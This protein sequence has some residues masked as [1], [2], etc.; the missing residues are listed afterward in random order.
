M[1]TVKAVSGVRRNRGERRVVT[2]RVVIW[3]TAAF[4]L[5]SPLIAMQFTD[6]VEWDGADF[7]LFAAM[8]VTAGGAVEFTVRM[9]GNA[10]YRAAVGI[11]IAATF[12]LVWI[13]LA[14]GVIGSEDDPANLMYGGVLAIAMMGATVAR[15]RPAGMARALG[16]TALAQTAVGAIALIAGWGSAAPSFPEAVIVLTGLFAGLWLLSGWFF[17]KAAQTPSSSHAAT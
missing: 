8:L 7:I 16:A 14:V 9:T 10:A 15:F 2:W 11:A 1:Y 6:Q 17:H 3:A 4:L 13:N 5:L 12:M